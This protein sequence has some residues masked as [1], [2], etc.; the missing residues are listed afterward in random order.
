L[1][2]DRTHIARPLPALLCVI[3]DRHRA[4]HVLPLVLQAAVQGGARWIRVREPD[5]EL[6]A[7]S[8]LCNVLIDSVANAK[9]TWSVR[10]SAY[11]LLRSAWPELRLA[12]HLT[13]ADAAWRAPDAEILIGRSVHAHDAMVRAASSR[14]LATELAKNHAAEPAEDHPENH[15]AEPAN[16]PAAY[17]AAI[18]DPTPD[19]LLLAPVFPT[20][21]KPHAAPI[22]TEAIARLTNSAHPPVVALGGV[23]PLNAAACLRAG[24]SG[25][26]VCGGVMES[27]VPT[28]AVADYLQVLE[29]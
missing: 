23:T 16:T 29:G 14:A 26:A 19:Y 13:S 4:T 18:H 1:E 22:G 24:A 10:P 28:H 27:S 12:V 8:A 21:C 7:Y 15:A 11:L 9:V 3:T 25:I 20:S 6:L 2:A 5:L 17:E